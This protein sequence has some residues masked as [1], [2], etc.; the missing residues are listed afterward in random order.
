MI[1]KG[2]KNP[3]PKKAEN[4]RYCVYCGKRCPHVPTSVKWTTGLMAFGIV[5]GVL[6]Y[7]LL[8]HSQ[9][10]LQ[11]DLVNI[12]PQYG[13]ASADVTISGYPA[14][15]AID[16]VNA[17]CW[18]AGSCGSSSSPHWWKVDLKQNRQVSEIVVNTGI[19]GTDISD[20]LA[21]KQA[22]GD[23]NI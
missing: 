17:S 22:R 11:T 6:L 10:D 19:P 8:R 23:S 7:L 18:N 16:G 5:I 21:P 20:T 9:P 14:G 2:C 4:L 13:I 12:A 3:L 15:N 1:C